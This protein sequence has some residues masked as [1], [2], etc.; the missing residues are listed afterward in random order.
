MRKFVQLLTR[1]NHEA[2][3]SVTHHGHTAT[4]PV[5]KTFMP[6]A[7]RSEDTMEGAGQFYFK[8]NIL[9]RLDMY[10]ALV[11]RIRRADPEGYDLYRRRGGALIPHGIA[12]NREGDRWTAEH[13]RTRPTFGAVAWAMEGETGSKVVPPQFVYFLK[14]AVAPPGVEQCSGDVYQVSIYWDDTTDKKLPHGMSLTY[15]MEVAADG[16]VRLL[17]EAVVIR[18][19]VRSIAKRGGK[20]TVPS[21]RVGYPTALTG[22]VRDDHPDRTV[23]Q[24]AAMIFLNAARM[25]ASVGA[26]L[27][28]RAER[29]GVVTLFSVDTERTPYFFKDRELTVNE[30]GR[31]KR[32]FHIVRTFQRADGRFV[33]THF[34]G[35][36]KFSWNGYA[37]SIT[38][39]GLHHKD[40]AEMN[41]SGHSSDEEGLPI[42]DTMTIGDF[43]GRLDGYVRA[44]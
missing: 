40:E 11:R 10:H 2:P 6:K 33:K 22:W 4:P 36:R 35:E 32:I 1:T 29:D 43:M 13:G 25:S 39:P 30:N 15:H 44:A 8:G 24:Q 20:F 7:V 19:V 12:V 21:L 26:G 34:R 16:A 37:I 31:R 38:M 3:E 28:V 14:L 17:R 9:D 41:F 23:E 5:A 42:R 18:N 27:R